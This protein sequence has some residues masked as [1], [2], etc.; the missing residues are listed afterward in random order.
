MNTSLNHVNFVAKTG[1]V[2]LEVDTEVCT[3]FKRISYVNG[4]V[5]ATS[6]SPQ[7]TRFDI[8]QVQF[9]FVAPEVALGLWFF[10]VSIIPLLIHTNLHLYATLT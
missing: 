6:L 5:M 1:C 10:P 7:N 2:L 3:E 4:H 9:G 8:R